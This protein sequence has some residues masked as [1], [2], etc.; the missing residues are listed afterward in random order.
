[1]RTLLTARWLGL[2]AA[3]L[4]LAVTMV[5]L[6]RWQLHRFHERTAFNNAVAAGESGPAQPIADVLPAV[7][8]KTPSSAQ[9]KRVTATGTY[10]ETHE[11]LVRNRTVDGEVGFEIL[12]PFVLQDGSIVLV[13][14]GWIPPS[15]GGPTVAPNVPAAPGGTVTVIGRVHPDETGALDTAVIGG[16]TEV[17]HVNTAALSRS[18]GYAVRDAYLLAVSGTPGATAVPIDVPTQNAWQN[19]AY[20]LQWWLFAFLMLFGFIYLLRKEIQTGD[21]RRQGPDSAQPREAAQI[22]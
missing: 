7:G 5:F 15:E 16:R 18:G 6:G 22:A 21:P 12:T 2:L 4:A 8:G 3:A 20:V 11:V 1:V 10:D 14:R 13:D 9:Y 17:R 19:A